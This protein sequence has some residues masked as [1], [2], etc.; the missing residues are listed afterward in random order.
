MPK[1]ISNKLGLPDEI[2]RAAIRI[3]GQY[4]RG[5]AHISVTGLSDPPRKAVLEMLHEDELEEDVS[6]VIWALLG[7]S[8][9]SI[10]HEGFDT[11][12]TATDHFAEQRLFATSHGWVVSGALDHYSKGHIRDYKFTSV[13][14]VKNGKP[15][16][17]WEEQ[18]NG[19]AW[20]LRENGLPAGSAEVVVFLRDWS[21]MDSF[22]DGSYPRHQ[23]TRIPVPLWTPA[24]AETWVM[25]RVMAHQA[26]MHELPLCTPEEQWARPGKWAV[27][28]R[29][30]KRAVKLHETHAEAAKHVQQLGG[31]H[32]VE[33]R[34]G[35][36]VRCA[37]YCAARPFCTQAAGLEEVA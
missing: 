16:R 7:S 35:M 5:D 13:Y 37:G 9:H 23:V 26:A 4:D 6:D 10:L 32:F 1:R 2:H 17:E 19:Y 18:A 27:V 11:D 29:G 14:S 33:N 28:K 8:L 3:F 15:K 25:Q 20:L 24:E 21:K 22:K 30:Q 31:D 36:A 34:P 12:N